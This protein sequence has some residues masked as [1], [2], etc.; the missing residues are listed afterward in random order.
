LW[1]QGKADTAIQ[2][3]HLFDQLAQTHDVDV[4]CGCVVGIDDSEQDTTIVERICA[5]HSA[6]YSD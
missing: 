1:A 2:Q 5:E 3:E 6:V 4:Q